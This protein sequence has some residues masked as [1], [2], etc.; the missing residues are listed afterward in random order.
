MTTLLAVVVAVAAALRRRQQLREMRAHRIRV[1]VKAP[2]IP[3]GLLWAD[4]DLVEAAAAAARRDRDD[5]TGS[6]RAIGG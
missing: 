4:N 3:V 5:L 6:L 2:P 1:R